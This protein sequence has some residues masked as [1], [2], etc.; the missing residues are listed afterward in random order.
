MPVS[1]NYNKLRR[2]TWALSHNWN[3]RI[4]S[5]SLRGDL[6]GT[7]KNR[8]LEKLIRKF[9]GADGFISI[10]CTSTTL[11]Q[12]PVKIATGKIRGVTVHQAVGREGATGSVQL[13]AHEHED[14]RL[15]KFFEAWKHAEV[16]RLT[17]AQDPYARLSDGIYL[18]LLR[19]NREDVVMTYKLLETYCSESNTGTLGSDPSLVLTNFTLNYMNYDILTDESD[20]IV[21]QE[22]LGN[23]RFPL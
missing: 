19:G 13:T 18:D 10:S 14:Y 9:G 23:S 17:M 5:G 1:L 7:F 15:H 3:L 11:P 21:K 12:C 8:D 16:N 22:H 6:F 2:H 20:G 4:E